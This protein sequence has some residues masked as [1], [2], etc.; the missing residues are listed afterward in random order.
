MKNIV[1]HVGDFSRKSEDLRQLDLS[2]DTGFF[3]TG[4]YFCT[5][6][7][8]TIRQ[9]GGHR[10]LYQMDISKYNLKLGTL[11]LHDTLRKLNRY[12]SF[13]PATSMDKDI[14]WAISRKSDSFKTDNYSLGTSIKRQYEVWGEDE[15]LSYLEWKE[16]EYDLKYLI[17]AISKVDELKDIYKELIS[18]KPDWRKID[19]I[20]EE[21]IY[22]DTNMYDKMSSLKIEKQFLAMK[23]D[24]SESKFDKICE[25]IF[26][27]LYKYYDGYYLNRHKTPN[28]LDSIPTMFL[29][30]LGYDGIYPDRDTDNISYGGCIFDLDKKDTKLL[31]HDVSE[32]NGTVEES[33]NKWKIIK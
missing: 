6:W 15:G 16:S 1:Y 25:E 32:Y 27:E 2:R 17:N 20:S 28:G 4:I 10:P 31:A 33:Y 8:Y 9:G 3:G 21:S 30:K 22:F 24:V 12:I 26:D 18:D 11:E 13:Y 5:E 14:W 7:E 29:K 19:K 23:L